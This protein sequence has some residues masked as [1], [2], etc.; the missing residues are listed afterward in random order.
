ME[1]NTDGTI[2]PVLFTLEKTLGEKNETHP[3]KQ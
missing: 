3:I 2:C 1:F